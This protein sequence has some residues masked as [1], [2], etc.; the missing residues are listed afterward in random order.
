MQNES[1]QS[2]WFT[3]IKQMRRSEWLSHDSHP[4]CFQGISSD[5]ESLEESA[6]SKH[7]EQTNLAQTKH[8]LSSVLLLLHTH[9]PD[10]LPFA[11]T[12]HPVVDSVLWPSNHLRPGWVCNPAPRCTKRTLFLLGKLPWLQPNHNPLGNF[13]RSTHIPYILIKWK[14]LTHIWHEANA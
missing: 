7:H 10:C 2:G 4:V 13:T 12:F 8:L 5:S 1:I 11:L 9:T 14:Q 6:L 3:Y